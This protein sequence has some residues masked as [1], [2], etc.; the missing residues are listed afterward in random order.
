MRVNSTRLA[1]AALCIAVVASA[2]G[3]GTPPPGAGGGQNTD[4]A[5]SSIDPLV[6]AYQ[7]PKVD[8][9]GISLTIT[10]PEPDSLD[11]GGLFMFGKLRQWGAKVDVVTLTTT[12]GIQTMVAGRSDLGNHGADE[13]VLGNS[14]GANVTA[15]GSSRTKQSYVLV[16]K[17]DIKNVAGL[18]GHTIAMSGPSGFDTLL[19]KYA[20]KNA[21]LTDKAKLV[22]IGGSPD[23]AT[24]LIAGTVDAATIFLSDW[25]N[26]K[27]KSNKVHLI[28][29]FA[30]TTDFPGDAYY[31][32]ADYLKSHPKLALGVACANLEANQWQN[33]S[34]SQYVQFATRH[35]KG[36][37]QNGLKAVWQDATKSGMWP[38]DPAKVIDQGGFQDLQQAMLDSGEIKKKTSL[39]GAVDTSYL[40]KASQMGCGKAQ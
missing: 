14:E 37:D 30:D 13:V 11:M 27:R 5:G 34:E 33:S 19:S 4:P 39:A 22:Q 16:A 3:P 40:E 26:L 1:L 25:E 7:G 15:I 21:G 2:C 6:K 17:N 36:V 12:S 20:L 24:A 31:A 29:N 18:K 10:T 35:I 38:T 8:L 23:R 32:K 28:A 9:S